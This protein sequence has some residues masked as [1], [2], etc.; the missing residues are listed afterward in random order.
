MIHVVDFEKTAFS[1]P[2][3]GVLPPSGPQII[4]ESGMGCPLLGTRETWVVSTVPL[5]TVLPPYAPRRC[6]PGPAGS[7]REQTLPRWLLPDTN[8][9]FV[10]DPTGPDLNERSL[11][12]SMSPTQAIRADKSNPFLGGSGH[13]LFGTKGNAVG[14]FQL[15]DEA[16][17]DQ[18][19]AVIDPQSGPADRPR[20]AGTPAL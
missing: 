10:K 17:R 20:P 14:P 4:A 7:G 5:V 15:R 2:F 18:A 11:Y 9:R 1:T 12:S 8:R 6:P 19:R 3:R 16:V 13:R